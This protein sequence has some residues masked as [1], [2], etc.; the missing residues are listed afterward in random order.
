MVDYEDMSIYEVQRLAKQGDKNALFEMAWRMP[1]EVEN[2]PVEACAWQDYWLEKSAEA[3]HADAKIRYAN[4]LIKRIINAEDRQ[5]A[6]GYFQ[7]LVDD[8][9]TGKL[10]GEDADLANLKLGI[11]LCEGYYTQRNAIKGTKLI[12]IAENLSN[13]FDGYGFD[14]MC[15]IGEIFGQ[16]LAQPE[17]EPSIT[18]LGKSIKFLETAIKRFNPQKNKIEKLAYIKQYLELVKMRKANKE[19]GD[20]STTTPEEA[21]ERRKKIMEIS[22]EA[23]QRMEADKTALMRLRQRFA[24]EGW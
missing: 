21:A 14:T 22:A 24:R 13:G 17:E 16:G 5:K 12:S 15:E 18:D 7:S 3:G 23:R 1:D 11:M 2:N 20:N 6:M 9:N 10:S 8:F 4:S 19:N